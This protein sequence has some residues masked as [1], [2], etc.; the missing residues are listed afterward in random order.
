MNLKTIAKWYFLAIDLIYNTCI[1][2]YK[3]H[4]I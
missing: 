1:I 3:I 4:A 2:N